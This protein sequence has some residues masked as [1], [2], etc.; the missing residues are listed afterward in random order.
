MW[1]WIL[2]LSSRGAEIA[3]R[4]GYLKFS[5]LLELLCSQILY[6]MR[7]NLNPDSPATVAQLRSLRDGGPPRKRP[8]SAYGARAQQLTYTTNFNLDYNFFLQNLVLIILDFIF[9]NFA[10]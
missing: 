8:A 4:T 10:S 2:R 3:P 5:C 1:I 7:T 6:S 9:F